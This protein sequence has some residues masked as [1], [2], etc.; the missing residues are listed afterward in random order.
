M[1]KKTVHYWNDQ[2]ELASMRSSRDQQDAIVEAIEN[3]SHE[4]LRQLNVSATDKLWAMYVIDTKKKM[5]PTELT[6]ATME[7]ANDG[8][9]IL[10]VGVMKNR[11][12]VLFGEAVSWIAMKPKEAK[13]LIGAIQGQVDSL[14][15]MNQN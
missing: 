3:I 14:E 8:S 11:V 2:I 5:A 1:T 7:A 15:S 12:I 10:N 4:E 6:E 9:M 13:E